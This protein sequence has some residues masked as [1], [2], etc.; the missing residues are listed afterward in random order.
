MQ[1]FLSET[2]QV[3]VS[4]QT[5]KNFL[6]RERISLKLT[7]SVVMNRNSDSTKQLRFEY[8]SKIV[9]G[10]IDIHRCVFIDES[11]F[12]YWMRRS[13]GRSEIGSRCYW[14]CPTQRG[15]NISLCLA[16]CIG[17]AI[18]YNIR[19]GSFNREA[20]Q[21]FINEVSFAICIRIVRII[22]VISKRTI[23]V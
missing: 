17:G 20:F 12:N 16:I 4:H 10:T 14:N 1:T 13:F 2:H 5:V 23:S 22:L 18:H 3:N 15:K 11:G 7:R 6:K 8:A 21:I 19:E 9:D